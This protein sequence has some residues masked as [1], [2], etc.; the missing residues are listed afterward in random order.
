MIALLLTVA[1]ASPAEDLLSEARRRAVVGDFEGVQ[2][3]AREALDL[4]GE[5][6]REARYLH[7]LGL[8]FGGKPHDALAI[9]DALLD[10]S[11]GDSRADV[12]F[13]R[14]ETLG[15]LGRYPE[16][17]AQL[18]ELGPAA[19][20]TPGDTVKL[21]LLRGLW[22]LELRDKR[23]E[24]QGLT[25]IR[26]TLSGAAQHDAPAHQ[27]MAR[28]RLAELAAGQAADIELRGG[29]RKKARRLQERAS[30]V[31]IAKDQLVPMIHNEAPQWTL[32]TFLVAGQAFEDFGQALLD[33]SRVRG[34]NKRQ[35]PIYE[36]ERA[37][38]VEAV[39]VNAS[40]YYDRGLQYAEM[41]GWQGAETEALRVALSR[42]VARVDALAAA[43]SPGGSR[44]DG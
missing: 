15:R 1:L 5:H 31:G 25:R 18:D 8:E 4:Q 43:T 38:K 35:R 22:E 39:W 36:I 34:L 33:E 40:Q 23:L 3:V 27:A 24:E 28:A 13:R 9:Y 26:D 21:E 37:K 42:V 10:D 14:A 2:I 7:A 12:Q 20:R 30:L 29:K 11:A 44:T 16:A 17:L 6:Q 19:A 41:T 32:P